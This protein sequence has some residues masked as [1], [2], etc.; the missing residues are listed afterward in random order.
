MRAPVR[1]RALNLVL[2]LFAAGLCPAGADVAGRRTIDLPLLLDL[3]GDL[4]HVRYTPGTLDRSA[5]V[6]SRFEVL[7]GEFQRT[8]FQATSMD[9]LSDATGL[10]SGGLYHYIGSKRSLLLAIFSEL[11]DPL[12]ASRSPAP[13]AGETSSYERNV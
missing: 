1:I 9:D 10:R 8:G 11:M 12:L 5:A 7:A 6:Q 13:V 3:P 2:C 4:A